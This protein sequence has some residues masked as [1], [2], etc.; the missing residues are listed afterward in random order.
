MDGTEFTKSAPSL[1]VIAPTSQLA[2]AR[3][4]NA[5]ARPQ[6]LDRSGRTSSGS[7]SA[8]D[9]AQANNGFSKLPGSEFQ[10]D[11]GVSGTEDLNEENTEQTGSIRGAI[12]GLPSWMVSLVV[13]LALLLIL[14]ISSFGV[15]TGDRRLELEFAEAP[16]SFDAMTTEIEFEDVVVEDEQD[17][18]DPVPLES[19]EVADVVVPIEMMDTYTSKNETER[20]ANHGPING[21]PGRKA[22][23][24]AKKGN[25]ANFFGTKSYGSRFVFVIECSLSMKGNRWYHAVKELNT[26]IDGLEPEQEFLVLLYNT[27]TTVMLNASTDDAALVKAN[28]ENKDLV[29]RWLRRQKPDG[30]TFPSSAMFVSLTLNPDAIFMLSDGELQDNTRGLL[31]F[32]NIEQPKPDGTESKIPIHTVSLGSQGQGQE[33]MK[34]IA[35]QNDGNFTWIK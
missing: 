30:G 3:I 4:R 7:G 25:S 1:D 15:G 29:R 35:K 28:A 19:L 14:A 20:I 5:P 10:V 17:L 27:R 11:V 8:F 6:T 2:A 21:L 13:H 32:W 12:Q 23:Q 34:S 33:M 18:L 9:N 31:Q 24:V 22:A 16:A 26:A